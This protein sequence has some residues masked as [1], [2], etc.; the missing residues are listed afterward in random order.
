[1]RK[2]ATCILALS[3]LM[4]AAGQGP[5]P[6]VGATTNWAGHSGDA[7]ET[8]YSRLD[9]INVDNIQHLG[10]AWFLDLPGEASLEATP[11]AVNGILYFTGSYGKVYAVDGVNGNLLWTYDPQVWKHNPAKMHLNFP[12]NRGV[13]YADG[14]IFSAALDGRLFALDAKTGKHLWTVETTPR[15]SLH[16][17]TGAPLTFNGKV[18]IGNAGADFGDAWL[19]DRLRPGDGK[20]GLALLCHARNT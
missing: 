8:D 2:C 16:F 17:I 13:A 3:V 9:Q 19:C 15:D 20:A 1:M 14:R 11:L 5:A 10:L 18:I 6:S 7:D 12:V 4:L